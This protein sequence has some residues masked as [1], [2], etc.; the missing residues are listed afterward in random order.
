MSGFP[1]MPLFVKDYLIDTYTL[2]LEQSGA[3]LHLLMHMWEK[4]GTLPDNDNDLAAMTKCG[5]RKWRSIRP[6]LEPFFTIENGMWT[7]SRLSKEL[8]YV[9]RKLESLSTAGR[10]GGLRKPTRVEENQ[11]VKTSPAFSQ[12]S[13]AQAPTLTLT[14]TELTIDVNSPPNPQGGNASDQDIPDDQPLY[15]PEQTNDWPTKAFEKFYDLYPHKIGRGAAEKK[16]EQIR[17][18]KDPPTWAELITGLNRYVAKTDDRPWCNPSTWLNQGRW[19]DA[20]ANET[21]GTQSKQSGVSA[22]LDLVFGPDGGDMGTA[23]G[24]FAGVGQGAADH[25]TGTEAVG[26]SGARRSTQSSF[27]SSFEASD[28]SGAIVTAFPGRR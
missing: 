7:N 4:G 9:E 16:F 28:G 19:S 15:I 2:S 12:T 5:T 23:N 20:P 13:Q 14:P 3:Y 11:E 26:D 10:K 8:Q 17:K 6:K 22:A 25:I 21:N 1:H 18:S 24:N 27:A